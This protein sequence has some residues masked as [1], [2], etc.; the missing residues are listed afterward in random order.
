MSLGGPVSDA[1]DA[2]VEALGASGVKVAL[3]AGNESDDA[4]NHSPARANGPNIYT[5]SAINSSD[6]Y[7]SFSNYGNP[8]IDFAAPGVGVLST[9][10]GGYASYSGTSMASPHVCGIL[11]WGTPRNGGAVIGDPDGAVDQVAIK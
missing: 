5:V 10:P 7:A 6:T 8:P 3:A 11:I 1:L 9:V 4:N 2:A